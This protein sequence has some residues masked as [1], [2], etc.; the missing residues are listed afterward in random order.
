[1][2]SFAFGPGRRYSEHM[3]RGFLWL[4]LHTVLG[5]HQLNKDMKAFY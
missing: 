2:Y 4:C 5:K 3:R 1:M